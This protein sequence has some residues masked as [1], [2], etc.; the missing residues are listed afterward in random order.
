MEEQRLRIERENANLEAA[1]A[2]IR[3]MEARKKE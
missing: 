2:K 1:L 3:A